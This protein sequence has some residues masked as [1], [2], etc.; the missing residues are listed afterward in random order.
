VTTIHNREKKLKTLLK[1][2]KGRCWIC[3]GIMS[4]ETISFD[5]LIPKSMGGMA[6]L[7]NLKLA[8]AA[9]NHKRGSSME[10]VLIHCGGCVAMKYA[11]AK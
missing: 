9:C 11:A 8:H 5:H 3:N 1:R 6:E 10:G 2:Q 7:D 4:K